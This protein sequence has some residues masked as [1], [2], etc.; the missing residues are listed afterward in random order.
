MTWRSAIRSI[1]PQDG[2]TFTGIVIVKIWNLKALFNNKKIE[3]SYYDIISN[4][5]FG[6]LTFSYT[7]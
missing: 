5:I 2:Y 7:N 1:V 4:I 3:I 6:S